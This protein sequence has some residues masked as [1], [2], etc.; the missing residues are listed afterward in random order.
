[1][2]SERMDFLWGMLVF[3]FFFWSGDVTKTNK[4]MYHPVGAA[5]QIFHSVMNRVKAHSFSSCLNQRSLPSLAWAQF[6]F[7][8]MSYDDAESLVWE[9]TNRQQ[10]VLL[11]CVFSAIYNTFTGVSSLPRRFLLLKVAADM[12]LPLI[13]EWTQRPF[14]DNSSWEKCFGSF[15]SSAKDDWQCQDLVLLQFHQ[16]HLS[17]VQ[18]VGLFSSLEEI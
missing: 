14:S 11:C 15:S 13:L 9:S 5:K 16:T 1:M 8:R 12:D 3:F 7:F 4:Q 6:W 2:A 17:Q 10:R 18:C